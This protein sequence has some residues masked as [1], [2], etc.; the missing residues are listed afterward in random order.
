MP[1]SCR[2]AVAAMWL[3]S[4]SPVMRQDHVAGDKVVVDYSGKKIAIVNPATG[5]VRGASSRRR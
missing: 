2:L 3:K 4:V 1:S 5:E